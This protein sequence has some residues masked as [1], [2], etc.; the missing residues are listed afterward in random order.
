[1][2]TRTHTP[3]R[4][5]RSAAAGSWMALLAATTLGDAADTLHA[6]VRAVGLSEGA[7]YRLVVQSY[8]ET[9]G[10][11]PGR[12]S[13]PVGSLQRAVTA[14]ELRQGVHVDLLELRESAPVSHADGPLVVA[15]IEAGEPNLEFDGRAARPAPGSVYGAVKRTARQDRVHISLNRKLA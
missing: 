6:E 15:W 8:D 1:M 3:L 9:D 5:A 12:H 4:T 13:R 10:R 7:A 14:A 2:A 11:V